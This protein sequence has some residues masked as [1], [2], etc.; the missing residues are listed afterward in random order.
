MR[1]KNRTWIFKFWRKKIARKGSFFSIKRNSSQEIQIVYYQ[2][3][4]EFLHQQQQQA[5]EILINLIYAKLYRYLK[6]FSFDVRLNSTCVWSQNNDLNLI[7]YN[8]QAGASILWDIFW[9]NF[10][11]IESLRCHVVYKLIFQKI[12][13]ENVS[14]STFCLFQS[15]NYDFQQ[16]ISK[17]LVSFRLALK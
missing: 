11:I 13:A 8:F 1:I 16:G 15:K 12:Y 9:Y 3:E 6:S 2:R 17:N 7:Y 5:G 4:D 14:F 10:E